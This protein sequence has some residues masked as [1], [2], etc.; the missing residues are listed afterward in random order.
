[1][2]DKGRMAVLGTLT[3]ISG[4]FVAMS[5]PTS[6]RAQAPAATAAA[7]TV[8][9]AEVV[10]SIGDRKF[11][12]A[13][14]D[15]MFAL[16]PPQYQSLGKKGFADEFAALLGLVI[17]AEQQQLDQ[18]DQFRRM[19]DFN[20]HALLAQLMMGKLA[21][22][23]GSVGPE[24]VSYFYQTHQQD[25]EQA[26]V[27]GIYI[28]FGSP[29]GSASGTRTASA[30]P[31]LTEQQAMNKAMQL[32]MRIQSGQN[33]AEIAKAESEHPTAS[34]GGDFGYVNRNAQGGPLP[35]NL[36]SAIFTLQ[37]SRVS[38]PIKDR[39][40]YFIFRM[41]EKRIQPLEELQ[42]QIQAILG[43][44]KLSR[45]LEVVKQNHPATL[46]PGYFADAPAATPPA[47]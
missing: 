18:S 31:Q 23:Y 12:A 3:L 33:M 45:R 25:F 14:F 29:T 44:E 10:F 30:M 28:P 1:M 17:E 19:V 43:R 5:F 2:M 6:V 39:S 34:K 38:A 21:E 37:T 4:F 9:P 11:T 46:H 7:G 22:Q 41:E 27:T 15:A 26:K 8:S 47:R 16:L 40:G 42:S 35:P 36:V 32:R 24:E 13:E 20:R